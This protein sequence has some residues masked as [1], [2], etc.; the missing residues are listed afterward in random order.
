MSREG[1]EE[2]NVSLGPRGNSEDRE[3]DKGGLKMPLS[4]GQQEVGVRFPAEAGTW[5]AGSLPG[6][7]A[8]CAQRA[9]N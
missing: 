7:G 1:L 8:G 5:A 6:W 4:P 3:E 2:D 9:S